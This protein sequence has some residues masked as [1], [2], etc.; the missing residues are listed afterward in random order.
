MRIMR[1]ASLRG[2][3]AVNGYS[4]C[5]DATCGDMVNLQTHSASDALASATSLAPGT[6]FDPQLPDTSVLAAQG[7]V[8]ALTAVAAGYWWLVVVPS[9][10]AALGRS[11]RLGPL[12]TY[13]QELEGPEATQERCLD[14]PIVATGVLLLL[15]SAAGV[16]QQQLLR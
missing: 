14:N 7:F 12:N 9:E 15:A 11:K 4:P 13:L 10:R 8:L 6:T 3:F 1:P 5:Q 2:P 16:L